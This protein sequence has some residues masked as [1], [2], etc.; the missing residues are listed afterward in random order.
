MEKYS[1]KLLLL[2][3]DDLSNSYGF[4]KFL[5]SSLGSQFLSILLGDEVFSNDEVMSYCLQMGVVNL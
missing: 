3:L 1:D 2:I 4:D 5:S